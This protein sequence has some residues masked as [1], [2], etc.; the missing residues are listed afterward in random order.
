ML[1]RARQ[2]RITHGI[3]GIIWHQGENDQGAD[4]PTGGYGWETYQRLF[5]EMAG[6]WK[7]DYPNV[8]HYYVFQIWPNACAMGGRDGSGDRLREQQRTLPR[9]FSNMSILSTLGVRPP[10]GCHYPLEG[11][12]EFA[13]MLEPLIE[14]DHHGR[15]PRESI[16]SPNLLGA[17]R[18]ADD[19]I[20]LDFDQPVRWDDSLIG[21]FYLGGEKGM[22]AGGSVTGNR[23]TLRLASP[24]KATHI[25][26]VKESSWNQDTL[27]MG[28]NGLAALTFCE[29][30][31]QHDR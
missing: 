26:Y 19:A 8:Q 12:A 9:L 30:P 17:V 3:R 24:V 10:G 7:R 13:R 1:W 16:T 21:Q 6:G 23:L 14:R 11:W 27:L 31:I 20:G 22:I 29:V 5:V 18:L 2:A 28:T 4:G 15:V 25:T